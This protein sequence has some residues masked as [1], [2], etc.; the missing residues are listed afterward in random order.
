MS[1]SHVVSIQVGKPAAEV[2]AF[3]ADP[4]KLSRW[5]F[6][7]WETEI[8]ADGLV[9]GTSLF[10]GA[11]TYLRI[12]PDEER[13]SIDYRLGSKPDTLVPRINVRVVPGANLGHGENISILTFIAWRAAQMDEAR[14]RR[15]TAAHELEVVLIKNLL[16]SGRG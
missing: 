1:E 16:E 11:K 3:M 12:D 9:L 4:T 10:D 6:G 2:F 14:W 5:S 8:S 13:L 15:L 7:T